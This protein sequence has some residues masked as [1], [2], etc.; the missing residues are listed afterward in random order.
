M[1]T[2]HKSVD[3]DQ[4]DRFIETARQWAYVAILAVGVGAGVAF[5]QGGTPNPEAHLQAR[6]IAAACEPPARWTAAEA[7]TGRQICGAFTQGLTVGIYY[8]QGAAHQGIRTCMPTDASLKPADA[9]RLFLDYVKAHPEHLFGTAGVEM[10]TAIL[11][12]YRC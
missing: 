10:T 4:R 3:P 6:E 11:L 9:E 5:A 7:K 8:M 2:Q 12:H 1:M